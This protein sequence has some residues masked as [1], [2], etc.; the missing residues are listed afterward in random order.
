V[1]EPGRFI[2]R[3]GWLTL[4]AD[5]LAI[6]DNYPNAGFNNKKYSHETTLRLAVLAIGIS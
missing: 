2:F 1:T 5:D 3:F 4:T 6:W